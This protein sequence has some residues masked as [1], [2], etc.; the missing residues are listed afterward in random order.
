MTRAIAALAVLLSYAVLTI[1]IDQ[2]W[3]GAWRSS[4]FLHP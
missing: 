2:R 4:Q 3:R 1:W